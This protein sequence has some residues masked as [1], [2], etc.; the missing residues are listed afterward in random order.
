MDL[1]DRPCLIVGGGHLALRKAEVIAKAGARIRIV[2][3][4]IV[5]KE[6]DQRLTALADTVHVREFVPRD[7]EGSVLVIAATN[8]GDVNASVSEAARAQNIPVNVVDNAELSTVI[9]PTIIDRSPLVIAISSGGASPVL[10]RQLRTR[11]EAIIPATYGRLAAFAGR[12]RGRVR[13]AV[14]DGDARRRLWE[15]ILEGPVGEAV[16]AG[17]ERDAERLLAEALDDQSDRVDPGEVYLVGAGP[18]DPD[19]LTLRALRL[20]QQ[21]DIVLYDNLVSGEVMERVRRDA[22]K[23]Y[24]GKRR[25]SPGLRQNAIDELMV[26]H[27][28]N[29]KRVLRLKGGDPFI[30][31]R[32]G[33]E[34]ATLGKH[35]VA[36]QV[37]PGITAAN[38][39]AAY[40]GIPLTHRDYSQ[41]VRFVTGHLKDD[42]VNLDWP[43]LARPNQTLVFYM[44]L[45]G[46]RSICEQLVAHG[47]APRTPAALIENGTL[48]DQRLILGTLADLADGVEQ[49]NIKGPTIT[50]VGEV[51]RL[52]D[53]LKWRDTVTPP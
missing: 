47:A 14:A 32:G 24:V 31:A 16:L 50:I 51:V 2:S 10:L 20:M 3:K 22:E 9:F 17:R 48:P 21:A 4:E 18:G 43:E 53:S 8:D 1:R 26:K 29:G 7:V 45:T 6:I 46:L 39:C 33:E 34:I 5:S 25:S 42:R 30:F 41:S 15:R 44:A 23:I 27:A 49:E 35:G 12:F 13:D 19:L 36:F 28:R 11:L 52:H 40:A 38:G 37:V